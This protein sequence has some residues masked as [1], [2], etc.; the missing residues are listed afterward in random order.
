MINDRLKGKATI[1][2][3]GGSGIGAECARRLAAEGASVCVADL[4]VESAE[5]IA[6]W[7]TDN[8][9]QAFAL[10]IDIAD[11]D[12]VNEA[13]K[14]AVER[15]GGLDGAHVNAADLRVIYEDS[16]VLAEELRVFDRTIAVNLR[17]HVLCTRAVLPHLLARDGGA[18]VYTSSGASISGDQARPAYAS[19][20]AGLEALMRHVAS[21][22]GREG[23]TANCVA[24]GLVITPEVEASG[25]LPQEYLDTN[26]ARIPNRRLG[27]VQDLAAM[28]ALL[29]S[30]EG[31]WISGQVFHINGGTHMR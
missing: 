6:R 24:P 23:I 7:I 3:G 28:V 18:I 10:P 27:K 5:R 4:N 29:L 12:S 31:R 17:G 20:K 26:L 19:S 16:D 22:W 9:G 1:V 15:L 11:E 14:A 2:I 8:G 25:H 30:E 21:R 13:V